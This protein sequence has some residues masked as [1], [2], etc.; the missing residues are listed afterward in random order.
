MAENKKALQSILPTSRA[1]WMPRRCDLLDLT[2]HLPLALLYSRP[3]IF[4]LIILLIVWFCF[5]LSTRIFILR[6]VIH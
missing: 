3:I 4:A 1:G 5:L 6:D 2:G